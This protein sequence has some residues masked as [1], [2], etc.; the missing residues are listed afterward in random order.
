MTEAMDCRVQKF[1]SEG[2]F[3]LSFGGLEERQDSFG[4]E[5]KPLQTMHGPIA[6]CCDRE[7]RL[8]ITDAGGRVQQF[9]RDG[10]YLRGFGEEHGNEPGQFLAPHGVAI[11]S[12]EPA[13]YVVDAYNHRVQKFDVDEPSHR[14]RSRSCRPS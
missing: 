2:M 12:R 14:F 8:W 13:L 4:R 9:T 5:F 11:D 10:R 6:I 3:L 1:T 7:D